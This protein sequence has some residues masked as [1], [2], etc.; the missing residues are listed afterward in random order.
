MSANAD[1]SRKLSIVYFGS[2]PLAATSLE[3]LHDHFDIECVVTKPRPPHHKGSVPVIE[4]CVTHKL[5]YITPG[6]KAELTAHIAKERFRS[7]VGV[8]I[9]Y[10]IIIGREVIETFPLGI[11]NSHFSLLPQWRGAD[12]ITFAILSGQEETGVSLMLID[13]KMD[14]G[15]LLAQAKVG[16]DQMTNTTSL[17]SELVDVSNALMVEV[18][19]LYAKGNIQPVPQ[20]SGIAPTNTPSYSR[21][22]TKADGVLDWRKPAEQLE[23]EIRA[24]TEWPKSRTMLGPVEVVVV[25]AHAVPSTMAEPPGHLEILPAEGMLMINTTDGYLCLDKLKPVGKRTMSTG[26]FL[27]GYGARLARN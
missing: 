22:L 6:S 2:G 14:E 23:R 9:D 1:D 27:R 17:T 19:P 26:E 24:Y 16:I 11:V 10:G 15:P 20:T 13:E 25:Q 3:F 21:K 12:P 7:R 4:F 18:L 5:R 8:V